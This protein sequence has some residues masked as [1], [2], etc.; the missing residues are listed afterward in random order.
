MAE[1]RVRNLSDDVVHEYKERAR[2]SGTSMEAILRALITAEAARPRREL[3]AD[4]LDHQQK[5]RETCGVLPD[6]TPLI[7]EERDRIG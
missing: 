2:R 7:R 3:I 1:V 4:L 5:I 6:S